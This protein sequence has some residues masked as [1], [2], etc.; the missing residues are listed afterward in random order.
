LESLVAGN[1]SRGI[2]LREEKRGGEWACWRGGGPL[3]PR[4]CPDKTLRAAWTGILKDRSWM[5]RTGGSRLKSEVAVC[6]E[7][8]FLRGNV[9]VGTDLW[10]LLMDTGR[11]RVPAK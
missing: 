3:L 11:A 5:L 7:V 8:A 4:N 2:M 1:E 9:G 6:T 10:T